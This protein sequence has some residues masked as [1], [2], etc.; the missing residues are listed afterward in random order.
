MHMIVDT[1]YI[2][3]QLIFIIVGKQLERR[4][5]E[6]ELKRVMQQEQHFERVKVRAVNCIGFDFYWHLLN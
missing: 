5:Q 1:L 2:F 6:D 4:K 3:I